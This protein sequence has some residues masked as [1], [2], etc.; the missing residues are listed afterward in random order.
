MRYDYNIE[1]FRDTEKIEL[2][3]SWCDC[4]TV[5]MVCFG[6]KVMLNSVTLSQLNQSSELNILKKKR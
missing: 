5:F 2:R 4:V 6:E 1:Y 3:S